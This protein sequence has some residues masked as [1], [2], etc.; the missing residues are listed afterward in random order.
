MKLKKFGSRKGDNEKAI[1]ILS[2]IIKVKE[3]YQI[4][5]PIELE[6]TFDS[7]NSELPCD[8]WLGLLNQMIFSFEFFSIENYY[9][10][11]SNERF[12][13]FLKRYNYNYKE[14][15]KH[16]EE[17]AK[18]KYSPILVEIRNKAEKGLVVYKEY[19]SYLKELLK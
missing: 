17:F 3:K 2:S 14:I 7:S 6:K 11:L 15:K 13:E 19:F 12:I 5:Y 1:R 9:Q 8:I 10:T 4:N 18:D 16:M